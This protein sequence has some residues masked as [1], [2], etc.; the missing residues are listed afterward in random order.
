MRGAHVDDRADEGDCGPARELDRDDERRE[1]RVVR[2]KAVEEGQ[3]GQ[4]EARKRARRTAG[5]A[6]G[7]AQALSPWL[8]RASGEGRGRR[9][10]FRAGPTGATERGHA[11]V[12]ARRRERCAQLEALVCSSVYPLLSSRLAQSE[13]GAARGQL[14]LVPTG[15]A[16]LPLLPFTSPLALTRKDTMPGL[17]VAVLGAAGGAHLP[18]RPCSSRSPAP[19]PSSSS[20][21]ESASRSR[22]SSR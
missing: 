19:L 17:K 14:S 21:Q 4:R 10:P 18:P 12:A 22:S 2:R 20:P 3:R 8:G 5:A 16:A 9:C 7:R 11:A 6:A 15:L 13:R 1:Q